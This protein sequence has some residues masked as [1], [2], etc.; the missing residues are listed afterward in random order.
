MNTTLVLDDE[1]MAILLEAMIERDKLR[2]QLAQALAEV[3]RLTQQ[4][5]SVVDSPPVVE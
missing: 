3:E 5:A 2:F 1:R 4:L